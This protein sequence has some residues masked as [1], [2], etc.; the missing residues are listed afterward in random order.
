MTTTL[1]TPFLLNGIIF[2]WSKY[3]FPEFEY[4]HEM[5]NAQYT[6]FEIAKDEL[7]ASNL[8]ADNAL[9]EVN[10]DVVEQL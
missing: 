4:F 3:P 8:F 10:N 7:V 1:K 9:T 5:M 6:Q 2:R